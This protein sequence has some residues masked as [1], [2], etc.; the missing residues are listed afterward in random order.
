MKKI[1]T[2]IL[3]MGVMLVMSM[4]LFTGCSSTMKIT[5]FEGLKD[6]PRN[7]SRIVFETDFQKGLPQEFDIPS[8][9]IEAIMNKLFSRTY[10]KMSKHIDI[11]VLNESL[12]IYDQDDTKWTVPVGVIYNNGRWHDPSQDDLRT[13]L[14]EI[15]NKNK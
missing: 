5:D 14:N 1:I 13:M 7:P 8:D 2:K 11:D 12:K 10:K 15:V 6:L 4:G 9:D 3:A